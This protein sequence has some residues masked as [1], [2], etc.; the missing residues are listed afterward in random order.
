MSNETRLLNMLFDEFRS[1]RIRKLPEGIAFELFTLSIIL[2]SKNI[3]DD[4][5]SEGRIGGS[6]DGGI[7]GIFTFLNDQLQNE[8]SEILKNDY[9]LS[10]LRKNKI[11]LE[12]WIVQSKNT[13]GFKEDVF[14]KVQSTT[15]KLLQLERKNLGDHYSSSLVSRFEIFTGVWRKVAIR[16]PRIKINFVYATCGDT[17]DVS[18]GVRQKES[19]LKDHLKKLVPDAEVNILLLGARELW[20]L[21]NVTLEHDLQLSFSDYIKQKDSYTGLVSLPDY[22]VFLSDE[23]G[24][25][26]NELFES[27]VRDFEGYR[28]VNKQIRETLETEDVNDF[29]WFNNGVTILCTEINRAGN[30]FTL[31]GAQ[32]VNGMQTSYTIYET[33]S[34]KVFLN[35]NEKKMLHVKVIKFSDEVLRDKII[36]A[37]NSQTKVP[38]ASLHATEEIHQQIE[39]YFL[40]NGWY[41]ERRKNFYNKQRKPKDRILTITQLTQAMLAIG[42]CKPD[43]ARA[44]PSKFLDS[45][46]EN[47]KYKKIFN[48]KLDLKAYLWIA[49]TQ[50][51]INQ[52]LLENKE[53]LDVDILK[54]VK[55]HLSNFIVTQ[56]IGEKVCT[57]SQLQELVAADFT[58]DDSTFRSALE[59]VSV[60]LKELS[61]SR[62]WSLDKTAK[63]SAFT[64]VIV[65][66]ALRKDNGL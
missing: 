39:A 65:E 20:N 52:M 23:N 46:E 21:E 10:G 31:S 3:N 64:E 56:K 1:N 60:K 37:T 24:N 59:T 7:D 41:Y 11:D 38:S 47:E 13:S 58:V 22:F 51:L 53:T 35:K 16:F 8:D 29:W 30:L 4:E 15:E 40:A 48:K 6:R 42:F 18:K 62:E 12:L 28:K 33:L 61:K 25:L 55:F 27:N 17:S 54:N 49:R 14:D 2:K 9:T 34:N 36:R 32:V 57:P 63:N 44:R 26:R 45:N 19:D 66:A 50:E 43:E 5:I